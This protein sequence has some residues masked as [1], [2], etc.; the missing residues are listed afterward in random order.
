MDRFLVMVL[1]ARLQW[2]SHL[3]LDALFLPAE[4]RVMRCVARMHAMFST[5]HGGVIPLTQAD[6]A[7]MA[8]VTRSTAN[9]VLNRAQAEGVLRVGRATLEVV[10]IDR[11]RRQAGHWGSPG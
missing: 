3:L 1:S 6:I 11:L 5:G 4:S 7:S 9:R 8:G 2:T 10:D